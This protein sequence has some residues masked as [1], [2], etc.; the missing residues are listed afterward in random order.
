MPDELR[1][2]I[3]T[4]IQSVPFVEAILLFMG[5]AGLAL[6]AGTVARRLY[7]SESTANELVAALAAAGIVEPVEAGAVAW[8][9]A[10]SK[11]LARMLHLLAAYY[12]SHLIEIT[13]LIHS[14]GAR[15]AQRFADAFKLRREKEN[16]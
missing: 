2:F 9:Y 13:D 6:D 11:D 12:S 14:T 4:S 15:K 16:D 10:P 5:Q 7:V 3:L 8:R 1:R